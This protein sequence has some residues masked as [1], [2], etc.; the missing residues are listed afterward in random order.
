MVDNANN[1]QVT[2]YHNGK[3]ITTVERGATLSEALQNSFEKMHFD[4]NRTIIIEK[5]VQNGAIHK[6]H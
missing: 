4:K 6:K 2:L 3:K 1:Y 5:V